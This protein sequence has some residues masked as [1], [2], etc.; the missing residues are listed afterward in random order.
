M[1]RISGEVFTIT[2]FKNSINVIA[3]SGVFVTGFAYT[4]QLIGE[5]YTESVVATILMGLE[6]LFACI[7]GFLM[8][9]EVLT[10]TQIIGCIIIIIS[11][12]L[13]QINENKQIC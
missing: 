6:G 10:N 8:L 11:T 4:T 9:G 1:A 3:Y 13:I 12:I 5:K 2:N 7:F